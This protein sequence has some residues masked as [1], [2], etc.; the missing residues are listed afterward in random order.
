MLNLETFDIDH[1]G[2]VASV[3]DGHA[4]HMGPGTSTTVPQSQFPGQTLP[5]PTGTGTQRASKVTWSRLGYGQVE[6][7][8]ER[9][10]ENWTG[11]QHVNSKFLGSSARNNISGHL[12]NQR[13][14]DVTCRTIAGAWQIV[15]C[16]SY[17]APQ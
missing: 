17:G 15:L 12:Y 5:Q 11:H 1:C 7:E 3:D 16:G 8:Q 9:E 4:M 13:A 14:C 2:A 10:R 6:R